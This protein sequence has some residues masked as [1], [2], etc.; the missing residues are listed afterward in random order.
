MDLHVSN[1]ELSGFVSQGGTTIG[2]SRNGD[3]TVDGM[4]DQN[5]VVL[6]RLTLLATRPG[7]EHEEFKCWSESALERAKRRRVAPGWAAIRR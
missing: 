2:D 1:P 6:G 3:V 7:G 4:T 5:S